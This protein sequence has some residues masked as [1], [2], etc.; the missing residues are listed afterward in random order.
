M[1]TRNADRIL[2]TI[3]REPV[4]CRPLGHDQVTTASGEGM[5]SLCAGV[6]VG[7]YRAPGPPPRVIRWLLPQWR[8]GVVVQ[9]GVLDEPRAVDRLGRVSPGDAAGRGAP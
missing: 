7:R 3:R 1:V 5:P 2:R 6:V 4:T 8:G 9:L